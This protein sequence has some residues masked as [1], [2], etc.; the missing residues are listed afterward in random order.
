MSCGVGRRCGSD[1]ALLWL[2]RRLTAT[3]PIRPLAWESPYAVGAAQEM[4]KKDKKLKI[5]IIII[6]ESNCS[7]LGSCRDAG[8]VPEWC[9]ELRDLVLPQLAAQ[10]QFLAWELPYTLGAAIKEK[11][12]KGKKKSFLFKLWDNYIIEHVG[13][14]KR[15]NYTSFPCL[16]FLVLKSNNKWNL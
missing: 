13:K 9:S 8:W 15:E 4:A 10:I 1:P 2:W 5:I 6:K 12:G 11:K 16:C 14:N 7:S 3:A